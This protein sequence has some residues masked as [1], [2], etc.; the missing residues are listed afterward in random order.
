MIKDDVSNDGSAG[1]DDPM[2]RPSSAGARG[3]PDAASAPSAPP[4][5]AMAALEGA[6]KKAVEERDIFLDE[7]RRSK[8]EFENFQ[9]RVRRERPAWEQQAVRR[10]IQELLPFADNFERA[11]RNDS[12]AATD[13]I[14]DGVALLHQMLLEVLSKHDV[15]E[16]EAAGQPFDPLVHHAVDQ[17]EVA[18]PAADGRV[19]EVLQK[20]YRQGG[21]VVRPAN[22]VVGR[23]AGAKPP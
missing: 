20:G 13:S 23:K 12:H 18:D 7:L 4:A 19:V 15:Q 16:I 5:D 1:V 10:L 14:R 6:L 8:A 2:S 9:K 3:R 22:V 21:V 11:L 17:V